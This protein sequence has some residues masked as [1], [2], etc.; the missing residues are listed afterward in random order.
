M[1]TKEEIIV[2]SFLRGRE[3]WLKHYGSLIDRSLV[4]R[5]VLLSHS[6]SLPVLQCHIHIGK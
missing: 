1:F 5:A 4:Q 2:T 3:A 6:E